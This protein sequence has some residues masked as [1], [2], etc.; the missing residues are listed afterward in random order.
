MRSI[1]YSYINFRILI[2]RRPLLSLMIVLSQIAAILSVYLSVGF[3]N[4][5]LKSKQEAEYSQLHFAV[6]LKANEAQ[7]DSGSEKTYPKWKDI[8]E[9]FYKLYDFIGDDLSNIGIIGTGN[10]G[11][12]NIYSGVS[13]NGGNKLIGPKN[14]CAAETGNASI[15]DVFTVDGVDFTVT[16]TG[17][18]RPT[19]YINMDDYPP[20]SVVTYF[21]ITL[22]DA[23]SQNR[24]TD[25]NNKI[26]ELFGEPDDISSPEPVTLMQIQIDNM[27][28]FTS[29]FI[30][31]IAVVNI[32]VY[33]RY[34]FKKREKQT[35]IMK[36]CGAGR[37]DVFKIYIVEMLGSYIISL[38][39][40]L[41][42]FSSLLPELKEKYKG[43]S[44]FD[45]RKYIIIFA[46][47]YFVMSALVSVI[48]S[49][50]YSSSSP[51]ESYKRAQK[52]G[53]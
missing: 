32:S 21:T 20:E 2:L 25:I 37:N 40:A 48:L 4:N 53:V 27:F 26:Y 9:S 34:I 47:S 42:I 6:N 52:G 8:S 11:S 7:N 51:S 39:A 44:L 3:I 29:A 35:A 5:S 43:F 31:L 49:V 46:L 17:K 23:V 16:E 18:N 15:G 12:R 36:I 38:A 41:L 10:D 24:I 30:L 14:T 50:R 45:E 19:I 28:I 33:F 22:N 13:K 1:N